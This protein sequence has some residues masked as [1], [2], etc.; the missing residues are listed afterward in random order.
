MS[1]LSADQPRHIDGKFGEKT[2]A[3]PEVDLANQ[4]V[5]LSQAE[6][7]AVQVMKEHDLFSQGWVFKWDRA[8]ARHGLCTPST[9]TISMS[10]HM[11]PHRT[12][13]EVHQTMLH[14]VAHAMTPGE[15]H[16]RVWLAKA[17]SIGYT[18]GRTAKAP[19]S[20]VRPLRTTPRKPSVVVGDS[21]VRVGD[22][23]KYKGHIYRVNIIKRTRASS[24]READGVSV[25]A[26]LSMFVKYGIERDD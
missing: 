5:T 10:R 11:T 23:M 8:T 18:G 15:K 6:D 9:K 19:E 3:A 17:R 13:Q 25:S 22:R 14:E 12:A 7:I 1:N 16:N 20:Y 26:P 21:I 4:P 24:I 2:G